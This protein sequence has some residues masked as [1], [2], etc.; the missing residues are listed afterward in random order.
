M[1]AY[2][3]QIIL[4]A[5]NYA[6]QGW[7]I[8][9][10]QMLNINEYEALYSL[11]GV[12]YGGDGRTTFGVPDLRSRTMIGQ[13]TG[14]NLTPRTI[15]QTGGVETVALTNTQIPV[16]THQFYASSNTATSPSPT[17]NVVAS[18]PANC[19]F[20]FDEPAGAG[21]TP[22]PFG[23]NALQPAGSSQPHENRMPLTAINFLMCVQGIYPT[24]P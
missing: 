16:H 24:R 17:N 13:G 9:N 3:G 15:G 6:P 10:G 1:E 18:M 8:C 4:F 14:T 22:T 2:L 19:V 12:T 5:G 7:V 11:I 21:L 23:A 20:Y